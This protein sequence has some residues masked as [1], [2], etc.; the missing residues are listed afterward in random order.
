M[1]GVIYTRQS[2]DRNDGRS[3]D[4]QEREC[5]AEAARLG[6]PIVA[7]FC[8]RG[9]SASRYGKTRPKWEDCK[10]YLRKDH[11]LFLW[12]ASRS[13][14]DLEEFV[15]L[16][17]HCAELGVLVNYGGK[18]LDFSKGDDRFTG[19]LD[20]LLSEQESERFRQRTLRG[21]RSGAIQG[22]PAGRVK[23]G[24]RVVSPGVWEADPVEAP[25]VKEAVERILRGD[26]IY[27]V[28]AWLDTQ[29]GYHPPTITV[30][31][32]ALKSPTYAGLRVHRGEIV[33]KGNWP[34]LITELQHKQ[35]LAMAR[36]KNGVVASPEPKHLLSG[37]AKCGKPGCD[38]GLRYRKN[39]HGTPIYSCIRGHVSRLAEPLEEY[40]SDWLFF[41]LRQAERP[42]DTDDDGDI[43]G[44]LAEID[45]LNL[46]LAKWRTLARKREITPES[47]A[48][49]EKEIV[50]EI[51]AL[52]VRATPKKTVNGD[53]RES[54]LT[55]WDKNYT[56]R[57]KREIIKEFF[58]SIIVEPA[59]QGHKIGIGGVV[60][61]DSAGER[62]VAD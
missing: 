9:I 10:G 48:I 41:Y 1:E 8:D 23:W 47:F 18:V 31:H 25:K 38:Q 7:V 29:D 58:P 34:A 20:A 30:L 49:F 17:N 16:R 54:I 32:R 55:N 57:E 61:T 40:V 2:L 36:R 26:S 56:M 28:L 45:A 51:A 33:G 43:A 14:R 50:E 62:I 44:I 13:T 53:D 5:R 6:I 21:K 59:V 12:E 35:L 3:T 42:E 22:R 60:I 37:I 19:G 11:M 52:E 15:V 4:D 24:Y 39:A 27:S 46:D